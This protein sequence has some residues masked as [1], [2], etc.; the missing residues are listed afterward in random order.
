MCFDV[1]RHAHYAEVLYMTGSPM[2]E[3]RLLLGFGADATGVRLY[4]NRAQWSSTLQCGNTSE[5]RE[6]CS[7]VVI[8]SD[9]NH[10][11]RM[12]SRF[13]L[14]NQAGIPSAA[15]GLGLD[16]TCVL[17]EDGGYLLGS[18]RLCH[19]PS[20][21][22]ET[23]PSDYDPIALTWT[24]GYPQATTD[25]MTKGLWRDTI[26]SRAQCSG[27][28][29][30][31]PIE[32]MAPERLLSISTKRMLERTSFNRLYETYELGFDASNE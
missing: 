9:H 7:D 23:L 5:T 15:Y 25:D 19:R 31:F 11:V 2:R 30:L 29:D 22:C 24:N 4:S 21:T 17:D 26:V 32:L 10:R 12:I 27:K 20:L 3:Y 16:G 28:V 6:L 14:S 18:H 13:R 1:V 8:M